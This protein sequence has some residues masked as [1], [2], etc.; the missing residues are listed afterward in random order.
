MSRFG[1]AYGQVGA[2]VVP[3]GA[4][5][6]PPLALGEGLANFLKGSPFAAAFMSGYITMDMLLDLLDRLRLQ[7]ALARERAFLEKEAARVA[8]IVAQLYPIVV[9]PT[10]ANFCGTFSLAGPLVIGPWP[11]AGGFCPPAAVTQGAIDGYLAGSPG[12]SPPDMSALEWQ[13]PG[14]GA[15]TFGPMYFD[16]TNNVRDA[17][18]GAT[19][20]PSHAG[21]IEMDIA[22]SFQ[23]VESKPR[24]IPNQ[25]TRTSYIP[26]NLIRITEVGV[27]R[28]FMPPVWPTKDST[29]KGRTKKFGLKS[30]ARVIWTIANVVTEATDFVKAMWDALPQS[31]RSKPKFKKKSIRSKGNFPDFQ[32]MVSD[33]YNF[34]QYA[35]PGLMEAYY[36]DEEI[37]QFYHEYGPGT[38]VMEAYFNEALTGLIVNQIKDYVFGKIGQQV[39]KASAKD[40]RPIGYAAGP[41]L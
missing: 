25:V 23:E 1:Q 36:R 41:A 38:G 4:I 28:G 11:T 35:E 29:E 39:G 20:V 17:L 24:V 15:V 12:F 26:Y 8:K 5:A 19:Y 33:I 14:Y 7:D 3:R 32:I 18:G 21:V 37:L 9:P 16:G 40:R 34:L 27:T 22:P 13:F 6:L 10:L 2:A 30:A 31:Y